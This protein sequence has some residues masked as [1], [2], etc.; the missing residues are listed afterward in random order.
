LDELKLR[1]DIA[2]EL[3]TGVAAHSIIGAIL[4]TDHWRRPGGRLSVEQIV[5]QLTGFIFNGVMA[6]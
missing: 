2:L 6:R 1:G 3:D 4:W 5:D